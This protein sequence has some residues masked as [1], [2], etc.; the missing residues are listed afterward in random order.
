VNLIGGRYELLDRLGAGGMGE[1]YRSRDRLTDEIV[2]L[3]RVLGESALPAAPPGPAVRRRTE[4]DDYTTTLGSEPTPTSTTG[5]AETA[6][7]ALASEFRVLSSLRH[8]NIVS[9]LDYGFQGN[10]SPFFTMRLLTD[11]VTIVHAARL[12]PIDVQLDLMFQMLYALSYLH[13]HGIVHR[14]LKPSNVLVTGRHV[15]VLDFGVSGLPEYMVAGTGGFIAPEVVRGELPTPASDFYSVGAIAYEILTGEPV[16]P[17]DRPRSAPDLSRLDRVGAIGELVKTLLSHDP[18][19][20]RYSDA[21]RLIDDLASA[22]GREVPPESAGH[23]DSSLKAAPL[24]GRRA[25]LALLTDALEA[26]M[27]GKGG[28]W[29]V[30]GESGVGK[31]RLLDEIRSRAQVRGLLTLTGIAEENQAPYSMFRHS[32]LRLAL[33]VDVSDEEAGILKMVFPDIERVLARP[34]QDVALDPQLFQDRLMEVIYGLFARCTGPMLLELEDCQLIG[35]SLRVVQKL[36]QMTDGLSLLIVA[37]FRDDERPELPS[38]CPGMRLLRLTRFGQD[39]VRA[40]A[41]SM[42]GRGLGGDPAVVSFLERE[43]EGNAFFLI[44]AVR[45]LINAS[46]RLRDVSPAMLPE[47]VFSGGMK[48]YVRRRLD[49]LPPW[50]RGPIEIAAIIGRQVDLDV[51]RAA[52]PDADLDALLV[53]CGNAAILEGYGYQ[54]RFTHDKLREAVLAEIDD[55]TRR[56]FSLKGAA[57]IE[58]VYGAAPEWIHA[59]AVLWKEAGVPDKAAHYLLLAAAQLLSTGSPEKAVRLAVDAASQ[60]GVVLPES[61]EQQA[62]AIGAEMQKIGALMAGRGPVQLADLPSLADH[63]VARIIGA[64]MLIGPAAHISQNLELFALST[65]KCFTL[66]LEHGIGADAPKVIAMYA[67]VVRSLTQNS[68][69][70]FAFSTL[71]MDL[72]RKLSGRVSSPALFLHSWFVNHWINPM[73]TNPAFARD[74]ARIGLN[75]NDTLYGCFNAAAHVIYLSFSGVPLP[76]VVQEADRQLARIADRVRVSAFHCVLERQ[77]ALALMRRTE[78]PLSLSDARYDEE[79]DLASICATSNYNQIGYYLL[80][81][82]RLHYY[83]GQY[84]AALGYAERALPLLSAFQG[85]VAEWEFVFYHALASAA[86]AQDASSAERPQLLATVEALLGSFEAW[87]AVGPANFAHKRDLIRAELLRAREEREPAAAAYEAAVLSA[88]SSG[89]VHDHALAHE[90]AALFYHASDDAARSRAH[91][92]LA[93]THYEKWEAWAKIDALRETRLPPRT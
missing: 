16:C 56:A 12:Q 89:F 69:L 37:S 9:V 84:E 24:I 17:H 29:L 82:L 71:A 8:P 47:H 74:G 33:L 28:A 62:A 5:R 52:A 44:E 25:E 41:A 65:L 93:A 23:R 87:A 78:H 14:D 75:E 1:V 30:G 2:A 31:S 86:R 15:T 76:Q 21:N 45:E 59:Q 83:Y 68:Q 80:A 60:L 27:A 35:E 34:V 4:L 58:S 10:G 7:L 90:R 54:W 77:L 19:E 36:T 26:A 53:V 91:F 48:M 46:G 13:R 3:K 57:A 6:R 81:R 67:A 85:Q 61:R 88:A 11:P 38:E 64:L 63:R 92:Q 72:D 32:V 55:D 79:R 39:E 40:M 22:A 42:L 50:A 49:R 20:R 18:V 51:L 66:T 70:A 43:T 73:K